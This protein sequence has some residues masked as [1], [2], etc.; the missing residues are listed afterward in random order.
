MK[1]FL[2]FTILTLVSIVNFSQTYEPGVLIGK[3]YIQVEKILYQQKDY[4]LIDKT[5]STLTY[6][7]HQSGFYVQYVF[8][9]CKHSRRCLVSSIILDPKDAEDLIKKHLD[10][11]DWENCGSYY[12]YYTNTYIKPLKVII[13]NVGHLKRFDYLY[14]YEEEKLE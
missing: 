12:L 1:K 4:R 7:N 13:T 9:K 3:K 2:V 10:L 14:F 6:V 11:N 8:I 5:D